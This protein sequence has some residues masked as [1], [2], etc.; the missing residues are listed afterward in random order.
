M[1]FIYVT[2]NN[3]QCYAVTF[4]NKGWIKVQKLEDVSEDK[5]IL[6]KINPME[7]LLGKSESCTMT[8]ISGAFN[9]SV[10]DG[11]TVLLE[12]SEEDNKHRYVYIGGDKI[13]S[14]VTNDRIYK[15]ISNKGINLSPC[16]IAIG[17]ENILS[18]TIF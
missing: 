12:V 5:N 18:N 13:C 4:Q 11:N 16:S 10:F 9:K 6:Y 1:T 15:D 17:R 8:A 2:K 3:C 7:T 14:F